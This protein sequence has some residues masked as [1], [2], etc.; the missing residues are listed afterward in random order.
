MKTIEI[1]VGGQV[2]SSVSG[3]RWEL[4]L[5]HALNYVNLYE[6]D[7]EIELRVYNSDAEWEAEQEDTDEPVQQRE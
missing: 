5:N 2:V 6:E 3:P 7:G 4:V 1:V